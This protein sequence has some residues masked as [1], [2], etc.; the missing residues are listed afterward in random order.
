[1]A[2]SI[3]HDSGCQDSPVQEVEVNTMDEPL[4]IAPMMEVTD[5]HW[6]YF[7]RGL[8]KKTILYTEMVVDD[9]VIHVPCLDRMLGRD[10]EEGPSV[11]QLGGHNPENLGEAAYLCEK[12]GGGYSEINLNCGCPS[13]KV[14]KRKFGASLML[15]PELVREIVYNMSRRVSC[16][17][18]V[19]CRIGADNKDSYPE[20]VEFIKAANAG[21]AKKFI[22]HSRKAFLSGLST[23]QNRDVPPLK[24]EVPHKLVQDFPDLKF[25]MNGGIL[26]L[27][28]GLKHMNSDYVYIYNT[29]EKT[30]VE[31]I[32]AENVDL[33]QQE[34]LPPVHGVMIGRAAYNSP[35][36][37]ANADSTFFG[38]K[39]PCLTRRDL[40]QR[41]CDYC[42]RF[43]AP[44]ADGRAMSVAILLK[45]VQNLMNGIRNNTVYRR[46]LND[47]YNKH[48]KGPNKSP[49]YIAREVIEGAMQ[50]VEES[51]LDSPIWLGDEY[52]GQNK[53][54]GLV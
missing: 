11:I 50:Q 24:Y 35:T 19:K 44:D 17:V 10:I 47:L 8:T 40:L 23:K 54:K 7:M 52:R 14:S 43:P 4:S 25:I 16:P 6:R 46:Y 15:E 41:Y 30:S 28:Q 3:S 9:T 39:D 37:F 21:G 26:T 49:G 1:M 5:P 2:G 20:L 34:I 45:P 48:S 31:D 38:E 18:T 22:I 12:Y 36:I 13:E 33:F 27:E 42:D 29:Q 53:R 32:G 51:D